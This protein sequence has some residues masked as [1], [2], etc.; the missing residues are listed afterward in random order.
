M[1]ATS[2]I[3][4][5]KTTK[6]GLPGISV[7]DHCLNVGCVA[8]VVREI[9]PASLCELLAPE[10]KWRIKQRHRD[11]FRRNPSAVLRGIAC[12]ERFVFWHRAS[13]AARLEPRSIALIPKSKTSNPKS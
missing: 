9:L 8:E 1:N 13:S 2:A 10:P 6:D 5:A 3:F 11:R 12:G 4:W 7:R